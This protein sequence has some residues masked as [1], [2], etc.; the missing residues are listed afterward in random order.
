MTSLPKRQKTLLGYF[1]LSESGKHDQC[2]DDSYICK[3]QAQPST[4]TAVTA[5]VHSSKQIAGAC[6]PAASLKQKLSMS[7]ADNR[8]DM[9]PAMHQLVRGSARQ[10]EPD[11]AQHS[12]DNCSVSPSSTGTEGTDGTDGNTGPDVDAV[13]QYEQQVQQQLF[14]AQTSL[15]PK[16]LLTCCGQ[17]SRGKSESSA[18]I[19]GCKVL[20]F[21]SWLRYRLWQPPSSS[22]SRSVQQLSGKKRRRSGLTACAIEAILLVPH[23]KLRQ[24]RHACCRHSKACS[25]SRKGF[26]RADMCLSALFSTGQ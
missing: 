23:I 7:Q 18:T 14:V 6:S 21:T 24:A 20:A 2:T 16:L 26:S 12:Q 15:A 11:T 8:D 4:T 25:A 10:P 22:Q 3:V 17:Q 13:N 1:S 5:A 9:L 19:S